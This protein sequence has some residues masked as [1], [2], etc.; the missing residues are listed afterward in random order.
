MKRGYLIA[1]LAISALIL[2][3]GSK[4]GEVSGQGDNKPDPPILNEPDIASNTPLP[5]QSFTGYVEPGN[6][7]TVR[8]GAEVVT[9]DSDAQDGHFCVVVSLKTAQINHL[10][11]Y[12]VAPGGNQSDPTVV[13]ITQDPSL[14][15]QSTNVAL[16]KPAYAASVSTTDCPTCTPNLA[17]D[18]DIATHW[19]NSANFTNPPAR[20]SPQ[21]WMVDLGAE[22]YIKNI[23]LKWDGDAYATKF[24]IWYS[25][26]PSPMEPHN[27]PGLLPGQEFVD[28]EPLYSENYG[29]VEETIDGKYLLTRWVAIV[30]FESN[31]VYP[32]NL[33]KY[34]LVELETM[35]FT[36]GG[37]VPLDKRCQD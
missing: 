27:E 2:S 29:Q 35:G 12:S 18:G 8:G 23:N 21:W 4:G 9:A 26:L 17:N 6:E 16:S 36:A 37:N 14:E 22:Y 25:L 13:D 24:G 15:P 34:R 7:V 11:F 31:N 32:L 30:L 3:C 10:E 20:I 19:E 1:I 28:W 5:Y 33:Y